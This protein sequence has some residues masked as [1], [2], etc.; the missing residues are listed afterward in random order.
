MKWVFLKFSVVTHIQLYSSTEPPHSSLEL[1]IREETN[2]EKSGN[3]IGGSWIPPPC[4]CTGKKSRE[5]NYRGL[6]QPSL[7]G[8]W[9]NI[10]ATL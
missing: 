3:I 4:C 8:G 9:L 2:V 10:C 1:I 7:G 6:Q 5:K